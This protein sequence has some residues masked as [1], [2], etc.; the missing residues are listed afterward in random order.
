[1]TDSTH[2]ATAATRAAYPLRRILDGLRRQQL[3]FEHAGLFLQLDRACVAGIA[4]RADGLSNSRI[5]LSIGQ[6]LRCRRQRGL[7][8][9]IGQRGSLRISRSG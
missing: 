9:Y 6:G 1:M 2:T 3:R 8:L 7:R 5:C 4:H